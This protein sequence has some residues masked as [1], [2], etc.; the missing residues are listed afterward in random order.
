MISTL[1][2][3]GCLAKQKV[4]RRKCFI[5]CRLRPSEEPVTSQPQL[6]KGDTGDML[7]GSENCC[8]SWNSSIIAA[9]SQHVWMGQEI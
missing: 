6:S 4:G 9:T 2:R 8:K 5:C 3:N 1:L 7:A